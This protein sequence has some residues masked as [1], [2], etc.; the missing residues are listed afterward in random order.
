MRSPGQKLC[1]RVMRKKS[2]EPSKTGLSAFCGEMG[3]NELRMMPM[4]LLEEP[5]TKEQFERELLSLPPKEVDS[6]R[7]FWTLCEAL[8]AMEDTK[9]PPPDWFIESF[10]TCSNMHPRF[11]PSLGGNCCIGCSSTWVNSSESRGRFASDGTGL[12]RF[13]DSQSYRG[14][15]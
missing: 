10:E 14:L 9:C 11:G 6:R 15:A 8:Q 1:N 5:I 7:E 12:E 2:Q 4:P 3:Y 13:S